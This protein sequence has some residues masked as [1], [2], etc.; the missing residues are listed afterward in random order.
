[1]NSI[2]RQLDLYIRKYYFNQMIRGIL[3]WLIFLGTSGLLLLGLEYYF[4]LPARIKLPS[5]FLYLLITFVMLFKW[6]MIPLLKAMSW[7]KRMSYKE[8]AWKI[9]AHYEE[10]SDKLYNLLELEQEYELKEEHPLIIAAIEQRTQELKVFSFPKAIQIKANRKYIKWILPSA[11]ILLILFL[12]APQVLKETGHRW[13]NAQQNFD[14]PAPFR[15]VINEQSLKVARHSDFL[16]DVQLEGGVWLETMYIVIE[17]TKIPMELIKNNWFQYKWNKVAQTQDF[18][19]QA[20]RYKSPTYSLEVFDRSQALSMNMELI[21]PPHTR[22]PQQVLEG[23]TDVQVPEG[24]MIVWS[25]NTAHV[26]HV[27]WKWMEEV[28]QLIE[29]V[30][31]H[32]YQWRKMVM[33]EVDYEVHLTNKDDREGVKIPLTIKTITDEF[34]VLHLE[35]LKHQADER[36]LVLTGLATD[37]YGITDL[38]FIYEIF[39]EKGVKVNTKSIPIP[40]ASQQKSVYFEQYVDI[41][42][43]NLKVGERAVY[44]IEVKDNDGINGPKSVKSEVFVFEMPQA[45]EL[46]ERIQTHASE[47]QK[48]IEQSIQKA[49]QM[50]QTFEQAKIDLLQSQGNQ[51]DQQQSLR[52]LMQQQEQMLQEL[53][54]VQQELAKQME[55]QSL[56]EE[57]DPFKDQKEHLAKE[58]EELNNQELQEQL[59]KLQEL[60]QEQNKSKALEAIQQIQEQNKMFQMDMER[61]QSLIERLTLQQDL[62]EMAERMEQLAEKQQ[63]L[64]E[65]SQKDL[66]QQESIKK[67]FEQLHQELNNKI[68]P[69]NEAMKQPLSLEDITEQAGALEKDLGTLQNEMQQNPT[70]EKSKEQQKGQEDAAQKMKNLAK[71]M[72]LQAEGLDLH[73]ISM[74][75]KVVRQLLSNLI[76]YSFEQE[77]LMEQERVT[78]VTSPVFSEYAQKQRAL[79][80]NAQMMR[81]SLT[82]LSQRIP[83]L[84]AGV[85]RETHQ[86][87]LKNQ[88]AVEALVQRNVQKTIVAQRFAM[89]HANKMAII[90]EDM[91]GNLMEQM[92][93]AEGNA[94]EEGSPAQ[95]KQGKEGEGLEDIITGQEQL[96]ANMPGGQGEGDQGNG[97]QAGESGGNQGGEGEGG[98]QSGGNAEQIAKWVH[99]Q[100][101]LRAKVQA[102]ERN[103][104]GQ[105]QASDQIVKLLKAI[106]EAMNQQE[107]DVLF[108]RSSPKR[109]KY[110]Q[111]EIMQRLLE[112]DQAIR[113]QDEGEERRANR[114][115]ENIVRPQPKELAEFLK[116]QQI[117]F[118]VDQPALLPLKKDYQQL[119]ERYLR[120]LN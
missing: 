1:M 47:A 80:M 24:T 67:Q 97:E 107:E 33:E 31:P 78:P 81:D 84:S 30:Q 36:Q 10:I 102:M 37:D 68:V 77:Q 50:E 8:A 9:G 66:N 7:W 21:Y 57:E 15:F 20:G 86:W 64:S 45:N 32:H 40:H 76:R 111:Q 82:S 105:G 29:A 71:Q 88:E 90:L 22:L 79:Q 75:L 56:K 58:L 109:R 39:D 114:P 120:N 115:N 61:I 41:L 94:G 25:L 95:G 44:F 74:D 13:V 59:Q 18:Y 5:L 51:W 100:Q 4:Y 73:Q 116:Q 108:N 96:G 6:V 34:P 35:Q 112:A 89:G 49:Q 93:M 12:V 87:I 104:R 55:H 53:E 63:A 83:E 69:Q 3:W 70:G 11:S 42:S 72:Q 91:M 16:L 65:S 113:E 26:Q 110:Q 2:K 23:W 98:D 119:T 106:Q 28:D 54:Q 46:E 52:D 103:R 19:I 62:H 38:R 85:Q 92:S 43:W 118:N 48:G 117:K 101:Q 27:S 17:G 99:E 14:P 60:L